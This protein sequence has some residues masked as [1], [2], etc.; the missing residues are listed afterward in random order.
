MAFKKLDYNSVKADVCSSINDNDIDV[1]D[2]PDNLLGITISGNTI[3]NI[4]IYTYNRRGIKEKASIANSP[5]YVNGEYQSILIT[6]VLGRLYEERVIKRNNNYYSLALSP[7]TRNTKIYKFR[8]NKCGYI[9]LQSTRNGLLDMSD[10]GV[11]SRALNN[12]AKKTEE[13]YG[14]T[15]DIVSLRNEYVASNNKQGI[16]RLNNILKDIELNK[17]REIYKNTRALLNKKLPYN[18]KLGPNG[19]GLPPNHRSFDNRIYIEIP[20]APQTVV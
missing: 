19:K 11:T 17:R 5:A 9:I 6:D 12:P 14:S 2:V 1:P 13:T 10:F 4:G 7:A 15:N 18:L 8:I 3:K 16:D 20:P